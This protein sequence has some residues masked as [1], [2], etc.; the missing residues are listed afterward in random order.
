[1]TAIDPAA[2]LEWTPRTEVVFGPGSLARLGD[3]ASRLGIAHAFVVADPGVVSA[4]HAERA[5]A[6]LR[7]AGLAVSLFRDVAPDPDG[8]AVG[9][10]ADALQA[11]GADGL[12]GL[13]GGSALDTAKM[14]AL[15]AACGGRAAGYRGYGKA[16]RPLPPMIGVPTTAG[17]GSEAQ[18]YALVSDER[19]H[20]KIAIGDP[21]LAFRAA[22]LDPDLVASAPA[23]VLAASGFDA[24]AH[25]VETAVS[26]RRNAVSM[27]FTL[28]AFTL[29]ARAF[30]RIVAHPEDGATRAAMVMGAHLAG[31]AVEASMLGAAHACANPLSARFGAPHGDALATVLP[32]VVRLNAGA[33][34]DG[35]AALCAA[36]GWPAAEPAEVIAAWLE[37]AIATAGLPR[38]IAAFGAGAAALDTL[39]GEAAAQWTG[40]FNPFAFDAAAAREVY[41][42]AL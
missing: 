37:D 19:T 27:A 24:V 2:P 34:R 9:R 25:A 33:G 30:P 26:T 28:G 12:V 40:T 31:R 42:C 3:V 1:M 5:L 4:G 36:A 22:I 7:G 18:S 32:H 13:G 23:R 8:A 6:A 21:G 14:A 35:Y 15:L 20:E 39:A 17:T 38:S 16:T 10:A 41:R 29:L 11:S